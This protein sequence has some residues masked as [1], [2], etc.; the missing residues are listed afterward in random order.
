M[1]WRKEVMNMGVSF[2]EVGNGGVL[3]F[4]RLVLGVVVL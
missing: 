1:S 3:D 2:C 4:W